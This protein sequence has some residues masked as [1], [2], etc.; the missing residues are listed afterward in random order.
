MGVV[1]SCY[2]GSER[3]RIMIPNVARV[4]LDDPTSRAESGS[5]VVG[6]CWCHIGSGLEFLRRG[7]SDLGRQCLSSLSRYVFYELIVMCFIP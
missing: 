2:E 5:V 1:C 4:R 3:S 6:M 7:I